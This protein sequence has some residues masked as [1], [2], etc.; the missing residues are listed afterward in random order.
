[1]SVFF[2]YLNNKLFLHELKVLNYDYE[3]EI[4]DENQRFD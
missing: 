4:L 2:T 3:K 1:M